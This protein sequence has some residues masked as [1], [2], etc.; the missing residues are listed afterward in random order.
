LIKVLH[1]YRGYGPGHKNTV[2]DNQIATLNTEASIKIYTH[3]LNK[4]G[5]EYL[6]SIKIVSALVKKKQ[7]D[8]IHA[9]YSFSGFVAGLAFTGRPIVCSLMGSDVFSSLI[10]KKMLKA[11]KN[12]F[13]EVTIVKSREMLE[14]I[15]KSQLIPNG[16]DLKNFR[17]IEK[18]KALEKV[19]FDDSKINIL[20]VA[21]LPETP[22]KNLKLA[23]KAIRFLNN[24]LK[25]DKF[26][27]HILSDIDFEEL[28]YY[29]SAANMLI[30]T[31][32]SEG[33]PNVIKEAMACNCPIVA[34]DVGDIK[35]L[36][37]GVMECNIV[38][39]KVESVVEAIKDIISRDKRS[40][41]RMK[42]QK[43]SSVRI[44]NELFSLYKS[45]LDNK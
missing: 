6:R 30:M 34:T 42:I 18:N 44:K 1:I 35:E 3:I 29:Y 22:V 28:P 15:P 20:F 12:F 21:T 38:K 13:W 43:L 2:V 25:D 17:M 14:I 31:S 39:N 19:Q 7:I 8:I 27:L 40:N 36:T 10:E 24:E 23:K 26:V 4:G 9:H 33:S 5:L 16:V 41:G 32:L 45:T 37:T 11:F